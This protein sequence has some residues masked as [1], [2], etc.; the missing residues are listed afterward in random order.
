MALVLSNSIPKSLRPGVNAYIGTYDNHPEFHKDMFEMGTSDLG[1]EEDVMITGSD[2]APQKQ[3]SVAVSYSTISQ[4]FIYRYTHVVY[5]IA[6]AIT[7]E[8]KDDGKYLPMVER[9]TKHG[10]RSMVRTKETVS[11]NIYNRAFS[12]SYTYGDGSALIVTSHATVNGTQANTL[13][14]SV[15]FSEAAAEDFCILIRKATDP[16]GNPI[17]LMPKKLIGP[18]DLEFDFE[19]VTKSTLQNDTANNAVNALRETGKFSEGYL[20]NPYLT[21]TDAFF[22][23]TDAGDGLKGF[24]RKARTLSQDGD[25]DTDNV[26]MKFIE[27]YSFGATDWRGLYG[28]QGA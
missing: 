26:K 16:A 2:L 19:R 12:S 13:T 8:A 14:N 24:N 4:N 18:V 27:R 5:G 10:I 15:D 23:Q 21:D 17:A 6:F 25:F 11:A 1:Y 28:S 20:C 9:I 7:A 22:I 3:E